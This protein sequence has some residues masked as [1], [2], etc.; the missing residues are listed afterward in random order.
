MVITLPLFEGILKSFIQTLG[1]HL[2][3]L[4]SG[5]LTKALGEGGFRP[6]EVHRGLP[7]HSQGLRILGNYGNAT[8]CQLYSIG[9][10]GIVK[11]IVMLLNTKIQN[12]NLI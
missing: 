3:I 2:L 6:Q 1:S 9:T 7:S 8:P 4:H 5:K 12:G 11:A 10:A